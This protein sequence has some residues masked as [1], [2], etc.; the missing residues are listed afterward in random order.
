MNIMRHLVLF[1]TLSVLT[2]SFFTS[3]DDSLLE[4]SPSNDFT[5]EIFWQNEEDAV[6][7]LNGAYASTRGH[8]YRF[9]QTI[10]TPN[11]L[12]DGRHVQLQLGTHNPSNIDLFRNWWNENYQ[13]IGR[14]NNL[15]GN[16]GEIEMDQGLKERIMGEARFLRAFF[17]S[18]LVSL[19]GGV[20]LILDPPN[21]EEHKDLPR[22]AREDV[23]A[24]V[25]S[26]LDFAIGA[27]P[28]SYDG[29]DVGRATKGAALGLKARVLLYEER[30][31]E[32]ASVAQEVMQLGEY[33]LFP[34]YRG[35]FMPTNQNNQEVLFDLQFTEP[36]YEHPLDVLLE[37]NYVSAPQQDLVD[38]YLML[39]G[40]S[41]NDS[42]LF[43]PEN[44]YQNRDP[45][46]KQ[47]I[48]LPGSM[49][50]GQIVPEGKQFNTGYGYK[51][52][53]TYSDSVFVNVNVNSDLN[54]IVLRYADILLMYAEA[55]NEVSGPDQSVYEALNRIRNRAGMPDVPMGLSQEEMREVIRHERR[56][57]LA[58]EGL[59]YNDIRR[60]RTA[61]DV[62]NTD[63]FDKDGEFLQARSFN[64]ARDYLWPIHVETI[65]DNPALEQNP[66]Y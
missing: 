1:L 49:F 48:V 16:I 46:L 54:F 38:S 30:W 17:Y 34:D 31:E 40:E 19:Y 41:A 22:D 21:F 18:D 8:H 58:G 50:R 32:A 10:F 27:L 35:L 2:I 43:D 7:A 29:S 47:T 28:G 13:G 61:E 52:N 59:Y 5:E 56:I 39:D 11:S 66:G 15:L 4:V 12:G 60:W 63:V 64:P 20:P 45:R 26:D 36:D 55:R 23:I 14:A 25:L 57:E 9:I 44:P 6:A 24:Q 37:R 33:S 42:P 53:T 65:Q 62:M 51:K 3:C